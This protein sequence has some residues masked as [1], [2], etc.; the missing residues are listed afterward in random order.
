MYLLFINVPAALIITANIVII[1]AIRRTRKREKRV[2][3]NRQF[4][5]HDP[6]AQNPNPTYQDPKL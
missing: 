4:F 5:V 1:H 6:W 2:K 3:A